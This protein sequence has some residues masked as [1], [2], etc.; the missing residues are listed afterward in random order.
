LVSSRGW[1]N[2]ESR[3][4]HLARISPR[5]SPFMRLPLAACRKLD[6]QASQVGRRQRPVGRLARRAALRR[7]RP[8]CLLLAVHAT[9][10][11]RAVWPEPSDPTRPDGFLEAAIF[12]SIRAARRTARRQC[13]RPTDRALDAT[14]M[15]PECPETGMVRQRRPCAC[16]S[17]SKRRPLATL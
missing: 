5:P 13:R 9:S 11:G 16:S 10:S 8:P 12:E 2:L 15:R 3:M 1:P 7:W 17:V 4:G 6:A 14:R